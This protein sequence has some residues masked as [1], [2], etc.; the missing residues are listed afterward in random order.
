MKNYYDILGVS[1][2]SNYRE[3]KLAFN[4]LALQYHPDKN[5]NNNTSNPIDLES[6]QQRYQ[7]IQKAWEVLRD[8]DK[9]KIY[10]SQLL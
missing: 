6:I 4:Q 7:D 10:D 8:V 1:V 9:K 2:E 5:N 3:I